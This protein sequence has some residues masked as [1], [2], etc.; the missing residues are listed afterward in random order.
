MNA[1]EILELCLDKYRRCSTYADEGM[2]EEV[3]D[4]P[5]SPLPFSGYFETRFIRSTGLRFSCRERLPF[6]EESTEVV[7]WTTEGQCRLWSSTSKSTRVLSSISDGLWT[8]ILESRG[9]SLL[10]PAL[11]SSS[12]DAS[13]L[14]RLSEVTVEGAEELD[15]R[16]AW[17]LSCQDPRGGGYEL[18]IDQQT[19]L[20]RRAKQR[21]T[22]IVFSFSPR[23]DEPVADSEIAFVPEASTSGP[24]GSGRS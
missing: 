4:V 12:D 5:G 20:L 7:L 9:A 8:I 22:N 21:D 19:A 3:L 24:N 23:I 18:W 10:V 13:A 17:H 11:L 2:T 1:A 6:S 16:P 15:G 14:G